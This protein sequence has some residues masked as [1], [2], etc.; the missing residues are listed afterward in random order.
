MCALRAD[1]NGGAR[2][3]ED[4]GLFS[5]CLPSVQSVLQGNCGPVNTI[6]KL[7]LY[8]LL[9]GM[10]LG[11]AN[12]VVFTK[13]HPSLLAVN[14]G[15][16][17]WLQQFWAIIV[18]RFHNSHRNW[19]AVIWQLVLPIIFILFAL[20]IAVTVP[21]SNSDDPKRVL[22]LE[23]SA[24]SNNVT[25]FWAHFGNESSSV[26]LSVSMITVP[27]NSDCFTCPKVSCTKK[28]KYFVCG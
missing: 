16:A 8:T 1:R 23:N 24:S 17:L 7:Y 2:T 22:T 28:D 26:N 15:L 12:Y 4:A 3:A 9:L 27:F 20:I 18:K 21:S 25:V 13:H 10:I 14:T 5:Y 19:S 11:K 6:K